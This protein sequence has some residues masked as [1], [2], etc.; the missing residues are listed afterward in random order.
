M[1]KSKKVGKLSCLVKD[2]VVT[3]AL[4]VVLSLKMFRNK[5]KNRG[6]GCLT[7]RYVGVGKTLLGGGGELIPAKLQRLL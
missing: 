1:P 7:V 5:K 3:P 6:T 2:F 4:I